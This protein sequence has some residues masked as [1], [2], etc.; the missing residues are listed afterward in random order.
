MGLHVSAMPL[1]ILAKTTDE[2]PAWAKGREFH[3]GLGNVFKLVRHK[4][5]TAGVAVT[6]GSP[7]GYLDAGESYDVTTDLS[8]S[9]VGKLAGMSMVAITAA[10]SLAGTTWAWIMVKGNPADYASGGRGVPLGSSTLGNNNPITSLKTD[11]SVADADGLYW[12]ADDT[13]GGT[14]A[15]GTGVVFGG[16]AL[17]ADGGTAMAPASVFIDVGIGV[18]NVSA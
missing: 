6:A 16:R 2:P 15:S 3:D 14:I 8:Q 4:T 12:Q 18:S 13:W 10:E 9:D 7:V 5:P 1:H 11:D 17:A